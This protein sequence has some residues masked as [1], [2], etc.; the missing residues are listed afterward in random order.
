MA[1][2]SARLLTAPIGSSQWNALLYSNAAS[3]SVANGHDAHILIFRDVDTFAIRQR[4][5]VHGFR[6]S[7]R[8]LRD[9]CTVI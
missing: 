7:R 1:G 4:S 5:P 9:R 8:L 2:R 3:I 6:L